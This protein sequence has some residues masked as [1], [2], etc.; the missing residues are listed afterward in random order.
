MKR[1]SQCK[2]EKPETE[3][4]RNRTRGDGLRTICKQCAYARAVIY[5]KTHRAEFNARAKARY[6]RT[7]HKA[8]EYNHTS[9]TRM[10]A[11]RQSMVRLVMDAYPCSCGESRYP[12]LDFHH[13]DPTSKSATVAAIRTCKATFKE[14]LKCTV[15]CANCHRRLH[16]GDAVPVRQV[17][18]S[19]SLLQAIESAHPRLRGVRNWV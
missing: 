15:L 1:C 10:N 11:A 9:W 19:N 14:I 5:R 13:I 4:H 18:I 3:F 12:C 7:Q 16:A 6:W 17:E 8:R 2:Q